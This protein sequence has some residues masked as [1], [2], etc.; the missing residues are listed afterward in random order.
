MLSIH[1]SRLFI[2]ST[3]LL[4]LVNIIFFYSILDP[5]NLDFQMSE[6]GLLERVQNLYLALAA[7]GFFIGGLKHKAESRMFYIAMSWLMVLFFFREMV[8]EP[9]GPISSYIRSH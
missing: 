7:F 4:M 6:E 3:C 5:E 8:L 1:P 2:F 9:E